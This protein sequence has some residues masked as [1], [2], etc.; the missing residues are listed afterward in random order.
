MRSVILGTEGEF[1]EAR[2]VEGGLRAAVGD[3][4]GDR[5]RSAAALALGL[6]AIPCLLTL[7]PLSGSCR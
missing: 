4:R 5:M 3:A 6:F 2:R 1:E 7:P